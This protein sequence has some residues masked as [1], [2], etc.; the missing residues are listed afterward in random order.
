MGY[1]NFKSKVINLVF[2]NE[3]DYQIFFK[4]EVAKQSTQKDYFFKIN[5]INYYFMNFFSKPQI[6]HL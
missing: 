1:F 5:F 4:K 6:Q 3:K 2:Q